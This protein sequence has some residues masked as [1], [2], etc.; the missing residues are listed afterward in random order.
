MDLPESFDT[1]TFGGFNKKT[2]LKYIDELCEKAKANEDELKEQ[3]AQKEAEAK[4]LKERI[5]ALEATASKHQDH[6]STLEET[7]AELDRELRRQRSAAETYERELG[8]QKNVNRQIAMRSEA[9]EIKSRKYDEAMSQIGGALMDARQSASGVLKSAEQKAAQI[10]KAAVDS[11]HSLTTQVSGFKGDIASL[12][13]ALQVTMAELAG[14]LDELDNGITRLSGSM[15]AQLAEYS[16]S[17][18]GVNS[19]EAEA[20]QEPELQPEPD[21]P[22]N[23]EPAF[24]AGAPAHGLHVYEAPVWE[25]T[26]E[27]DAEPA[28]EQQEPQP[29]AQEA[30]PKQPATPPGAGPRF[31]W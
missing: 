10:T 30:E 26:E 21:A 8:E 19:T 16:T 27:T 7:I 17:A 13:K 15:D 12:R 18:D 28:A 5:E 20:P 29:A 6:K 1:S 9:L 25:A 23:E 31:F 11:V 24:F 22:V 14:R 2:V 4:G 3:I